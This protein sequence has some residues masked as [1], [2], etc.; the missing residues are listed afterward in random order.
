ML[1]VAFIFTAYPPLTASSPR[2]LALVDSA[3]NYIKRE[4]W[5]DAEQTLLSALRLEP[6]NFT[7]SLLL[8]NLGVVRTNLGK[9]D[10]ALEAFRLGLSIAP[11]SSVIRTNRSRTLIALGRYDE[12]MTDLNETLEIDSTQT[13]PRQMRGLLRLAADD[14]DGAEKDFTVL[15]RIDPSN[16]S[17]MSGLARVAERK[18]QT[19]EALKYYDEAIAIDDDPETRFS[20]ILLKI[21]LGKYS[22]ASEDIRKGIDKWPQVPDFYL[23]R[24]YLHRLNY[25]NREAEIDKKIALDK[26][27]DPQI[28]EQFLPTTRR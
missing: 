22:E 17:A 13:W 2:Y 19:T 8:S 4:R 6:G 12:A 24:G 25:R 26:G 10:D 15:S 5:T 16:A 14:I 27:A 9:M 18:G 7:N 1:A 28:V 21:S 3:D 11:R 23:A 20:R